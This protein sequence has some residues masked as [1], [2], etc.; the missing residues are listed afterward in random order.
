MRNNVPTMTARRANKA[1]KA[2]RDPCRRERGRHKRG[3]DAGIP[4]V[5][6]LAQRTDQRQAS[7]P[8]NLSCCC[9]LSDVRT[10]HC[11]EENELPSPN[12]K[13]EHQPPSN[14]EKDLDS[15]SQAN[16]HR[17][18]LIVSRWWSAVSNGARQ[19]ETNSY[20]PHENRPITRAPNQLFPDH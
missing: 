19:S 16:V 4:N 5:W 11:Q 3:V 17:I 1:A 2:K 20:A 9:E 13:S 14:N 12:L 7:C 8:L 10:V 18:S 6:Y 15:N